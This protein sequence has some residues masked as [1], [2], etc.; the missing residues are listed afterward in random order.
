MNVEFLVHRNGEWTMLMLGESILSLMTA[1]LLQYLYFRSQPH[2]A[3]DHAVRKGKNLGMMWTPAG[4]PSF[5]TGRK[6]LA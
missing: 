1:I 2:N 3:D 4:L 6:W 5:L